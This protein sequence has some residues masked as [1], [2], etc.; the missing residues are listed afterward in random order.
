MLGV[1]E[2]GHIVGSQ[3]EGDEKGGTSTLCPK[4]SDSYM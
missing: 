4:S 3:G 2:D 1:L